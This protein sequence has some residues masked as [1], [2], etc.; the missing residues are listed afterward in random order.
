M[1]SIVNKI[2]DAVHSDHSKSSAPEGTHGPHS[3]R[4]ANAADPRV[5][6]DR[7]GSH[8]MGAT[9]TAGHGEYG[10]GNPL[11]GS[12]GMTGSHGMTGGS[13]GI[14]SGTAEG[15][16]GPHSSRL[17]NA[18]DPRVDSDRD[19]SNAMG[20]GMGSGRTMGGIGGGHGIGSGGST[21]MTGTHGAPTGTHGPHSSRV[22]NVIDPRVDSDRDG[23]GALGGRSGPGPATN[24]AGPHQSDMMNKMD[25]RVDSDRDGS[26][27]MGGN[28]TYQ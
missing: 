17:A 13:H 3:S 21:G 25:P 1:S 22:G 19:G 7:D 26:T 27:T 9:R 11:T 28:K 23:R 20:S 5:D 10:S 2:K 6:S 15:T 8:S 14:G 12:K 18:A 16:Y 24:T 4:M